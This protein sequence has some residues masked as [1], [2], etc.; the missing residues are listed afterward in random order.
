VTSG[1]APGSP[2]RT[3][4]A[5]VHGGES[6][7]DGPPDAVPARTTRRT[8]T[9]TEIFDTVL[10]L[11]HEDSVGMP[12]MRRLAAALDVSPMALYRHVSDKDEILLGLADKLLAAQTLPPTDSSWQ[13]YLRQLAMLLRA[14]LRSEP[15]VL[16][17]FLR[18]PVASPAAQQRLAAAVAVL[19]D[20]GFDT[21]GS[22]RAYATVHTYT[23][24]FCALEHA[25]LAAGEAGRRVPLHTEEAVRIAGFVTDAQF[26]FGLDAILAGIAT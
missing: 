19:T 24:G 14:L 2:G 9:K 18:R 7:W 16:E 15:I 11:R 6:T 3:V 23:I 5:V 17:I 4:R 1:T 10:R 22:T 12:S 25:R 26:A 13:D 8:L 21:A 20:A